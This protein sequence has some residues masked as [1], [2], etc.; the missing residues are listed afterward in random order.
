MADERTIPSWP[1]PLR[2]TS[3]RQE[4][5]EALRAALV[6]GQMV[7]GVVYSAP[8]LAEQL[9]V[10]ATPVREAML[11]LVRAGMVEVVLNKGFR[12]VELGDAELD[13]LAELRL[14][15]EVPVMVAVAEHCAG[16]VAAEVES[17][18]SLAHELEAAAA[19]RD[20]VRFIALDTEF[21]T[22]FLGLHGN[23]A[24]VEVVRD[25]RGRSRLFGLER[26]AERGL[27][28]EAAHEHAEMI[29]VALARDVPGMRELMTRHVGH[30][31]G[32]WAA[33]E[34]AVPVD[35]AR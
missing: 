33:A 23:P 29:D 35:A 18:R 34:A 11:E 24:L 15:L 6:T 26:I 10:S 2:R 1:G 8:Q 25:L 28:D 20:L 5:T 13:Q 4:V 30:V 12:V 16:E 32:E 14:L 7:P 3:V 19:E 9:G 27:L 31:R 17:L 22:R 21:H